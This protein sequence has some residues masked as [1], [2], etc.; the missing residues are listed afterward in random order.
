MGIIRKSMFTNELLRRAPLGQPLIRGRSLPPSSFIYGK[1]SERDANGLEKCLNW[2]LFKPSSGVDLYDVDF[3]K[4]NQ[5]S[6]K[7]GVKNASEW[8][9]FRKEHE[10]RRRPVQSVRLHDK[11]KCP[12]DITFGIRRRPSTPMECILSHYYK[13]EFDQKSIK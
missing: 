4:I 2:C 1:K 3:Q 10:F 11:L 5:E 8:I 12:V 6:A 13:K 7:A 9:K